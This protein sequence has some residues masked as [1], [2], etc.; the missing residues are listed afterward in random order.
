[1]IFNF[2]DV[3]RLTMMKI[4]TEIITKFTQ[5]LGRNEAEP[6][7]QPQFL[8]LMISQGSILEVFTKVLVLYIPTEKQVPG[9]ILSTCGN[10]KID[11]MLNSVKTN[12]IECFNLVLKYMHEYKTLPL[13]PNINKFYA[14]IR[15]QIAKLALDSTYRF[16][17]SDL[18][19]LEQDLDVRLPLFLKMFKTYRDFKICNVA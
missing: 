1:M 5:L 16:C 18:V 19:D 3:H 2:I 13:D 8:K 14:F 7:F 6:A 15:S 11:E 9:C 12:V 17:K 4:W 10:A